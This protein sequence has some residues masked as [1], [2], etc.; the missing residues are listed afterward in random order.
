VTVSALITE[1]YE[2]HIL[3]KWCLKINTVVYHLN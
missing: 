1:S 2:I 3:I